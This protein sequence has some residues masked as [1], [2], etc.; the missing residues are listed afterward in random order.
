MARKNYADAARLID[1]GFAAG[2]AVI[3]R[4]QCFPARGSTL[5]EGA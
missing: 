2:I 1:S 3:F 5:Q 4:D